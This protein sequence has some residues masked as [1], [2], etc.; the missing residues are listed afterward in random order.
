MNTIIFDFD[1]T[2]ANTVA[3][4][5]VIYTELAREFNLRDISDV[6]WEE[7]R[8]KKAR[9]L[10]N[11]AG[12]SFFKL[13]FIL[14]RAKELLA[15]RI[16]LLKPYDGMPEVLKSLKDD[17]YKM[18]ILTSNNEENVR[19][20]LKNNNLDVFDFVYSESN[21]FGKDKAL[22]KVIKKEK[23]EPEKAVY[24]GDED[25]DA[26]AAKKAGIKI[27]SVT[28]GVGNEKLLSKEKP[29]FIA[30]TPEDLFLILKNNFKI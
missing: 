26:E 16:N 23:L 14:S 10:L 7:M 6:E 4:F 19:I 12:I 2:I 21:L 24:V 20:F 15:K 9:D 17:G 28:W 18:G 8:G 22:N 5:R 25:R 29:D 11:K 1:G 30:R 3:H 27:V 13:P